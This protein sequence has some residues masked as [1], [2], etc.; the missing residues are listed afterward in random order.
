[1]IPQPGT[2]FVAY[3]ERYYQVVGWDDDTVLPLVIPLGGYYAQLR[4]RLLPEA[5][6]TTPATYHLT[7]DEAQ[8]FAQYRRGE[9]MAAEID[10]AEE[11]ERIAREAG[12]QAGT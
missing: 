2:L 8:H 4:P 5:T 1:M 11:A 10:A 3:G 6:T 12:E 7:V 9:L